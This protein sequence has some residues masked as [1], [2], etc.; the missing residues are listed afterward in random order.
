MLTSA[1]GRRFVMQSWSQQR[2]PALSE[3]DLADLGPRLELPAG[4]TY[5]SVKLDED[6][7]VG[8]DR[9]VAE[10]LQDNLLN[11]YSLID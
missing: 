10:V 9:S 6:L 5:E 2:D 8:A 1:D 7:V 11:S 3:S 4:W